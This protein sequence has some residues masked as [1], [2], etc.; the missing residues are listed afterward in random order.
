V[1]G[2]VQGEIDFEKL[3]ADV[4]GQVTETSLDA[5]AARVDVT[6]VGGTV[7]YEA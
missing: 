3:V 5:V 7:V 2:D 4:V 1:H 6:M